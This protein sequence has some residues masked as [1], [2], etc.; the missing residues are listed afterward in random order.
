MEFS[1]QGLNSSDFV[2]QYHCDGAYGGACISDDEPQP[3]ETVATDVELTT[4][5]L[6]SCFVNRYPYPHAYDDIY[7]RYDNEPQ[8]LET[9]AT[10]V[11]FTAQHDD[12]Q[13]NEDDPKGDTNES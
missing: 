7:I 11:E 3:L 9:V 6:N 2:N 8:P 13:E 4:Q 10:D 12:M 1:T 5:H